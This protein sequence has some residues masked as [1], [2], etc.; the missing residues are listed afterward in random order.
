MLKPSWLLYGKLHQSGTLASLYEA[1]VTNGWQVDDSA[2]GSSGWQLK[3][4]DCI[5]YTTRQQCHTVA[6]WF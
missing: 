3:R 2:T 6:A 5:E 1:N 4:G